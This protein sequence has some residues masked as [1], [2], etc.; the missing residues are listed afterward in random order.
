MVY[1]GL[2]TNIKDIHESGIYGRE[3]KRK[4]LSIL[5]VSERTSINKIF[6]PIDFITSLAPFGPSY[7]IIID[8]LK[9]IYRNKKIHI[10]DKIIE[11]NKGKI[12]VIAYDKLDGNYNIKKDF[13]ILYGLFDNFK[14][15][16]EAFKSIM[17]SEG[18]SNLVIIEKGN[19]SKEHWGGSKGTFNNGL[20]CLHPKNDDILIPLGNASELIKNFI[21]EETISTFEALGA[22]RILIEDITEI[23]INIGVDEKSK[24]IKGSINSEVK[25][26][27]VREK[28]FADGV[29][30]VKRAEY[31]KYFIYDFP[32]VMSVVEA[33]KY[34]N[35][36][37]EEFTENVNLSSNL[38]I[39]VL[40]L[41][42]AQANFNFHRK[43]RFLVEFYDK[44]MI[45]K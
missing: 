25:Y 23:D 40:K 21:L 20:Y 35:Q 45:N 9:L 12:I 37:K 41:F 33:R 6:G 26:A 17:T 2:V 3:F 13:E 4:N 22:K 7:T 27:K 8:L 29:F 24:S 44:N 31:H 11:N 34:G 16:K 42:E 5:T 43:W 32:N 39:N 18:G 19:I 38:D 36:I 15:K 14:N 28:E 10:T 1:F 30:D